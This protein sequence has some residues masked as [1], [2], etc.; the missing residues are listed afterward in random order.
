[1]TEITLGSIVSYVV[2]IL[3]ILMGMILT[4]QSPLGLLP[5]LGGLLILPVLRRELDRRTGI[6]FSR[7]AAAGIGTVSVIAAVVIIVLIAASGSTGGTPGSDVSNVSVSAVN[8]N[9]SDASTKLEVTWNSRAQ[10]AVDPDTSDMSIYNSENGQ[11]FLVV[12][13]TI[14]NTGDNQLELDPRLFRFESEGVEYDYQ[15]LFGSGNSFSGVTLNPDASYSAWIVYSIP[16]DT[17]EG[18]LIV[19]QEV[20]FQKNV[21]VTFSHKPRMAINMSD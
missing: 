17:S 16:E 21:T 10:S 1:M 11:K 14:E 7:G 8:S 13:M 9:P 15:P 3:L 19:N 2:G 20:Y 4:V 5:L 12:R 6:S 18:R